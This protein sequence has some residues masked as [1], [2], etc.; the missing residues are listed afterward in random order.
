MQD[1]IN[2]PAGIVY[3]SGTTGN[4]KGSIMNNKNILSMV[5]QN[6]SA[7]MGWEKND[8][9]LGIMPPFIAYGLVCGF[10]LPICNGMQIDIIPKFEAD[11]FDSYILKHLS[12]IH[13]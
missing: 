12:L 7:N 9:F 13:I 10:S 4:P 2:L 6:H 8:V 3:T 11:K 5:Y 1:K